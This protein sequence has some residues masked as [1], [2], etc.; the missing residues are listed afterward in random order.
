MNTIIIVTKNPNKKVSFDNIGLPKNYGF[1]KTYITTDGI[2][3]K[4][5]IFPNGSLALKFPKKK[6]VP[7]SDT[8]SWYAPTEKEIFELDDKEIIKI[9]K[10]IDTENQRQKQKNLKKDKRRFAE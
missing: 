1:E 9:Y 3:F 10:Q 4:F 6:S 7:Y 2:Y 8:D 5:S